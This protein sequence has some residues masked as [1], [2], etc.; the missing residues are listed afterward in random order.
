MQVDQFFH[1]PNFHIPVLLRSG[2][3]YLLWQNLEFLLQRCVEPWRFCSYW[4]IVK[5]DNNSAIKEHHFFWNHSSGF[6]DFSILTNSNNDFKITLM[7]S[8][9]INKDHPA[10][11]KNSN[12]LSLE[13]FDDSRKYFYNTIAIDLPD[14][15]PLIP[16]R[17]CFIKWMIFYS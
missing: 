10:L 2:V 4:K 14:C 12:S 17:Y 16:H 11:N 15:S 9:L 6:D 5:R 8:L 1:I 3:V 7:G 13:L